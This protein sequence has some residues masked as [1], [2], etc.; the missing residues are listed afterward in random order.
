[1]D[2]VLLFYLKPSTWLT[3]T[4]NGFLFRKQN[5]FYYKGSYHFLPGEGPS[6]YGG[7]AEFFGVVKGGDRFFFS[8]SKGGTRIF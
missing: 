1:M 5:M 3:L 8:G 4:C 7:G 2:L 6:I